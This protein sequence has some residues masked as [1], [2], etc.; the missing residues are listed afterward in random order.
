MGFHLLRMLLAALSLVI[1]ACGS[2]GESTSD[3]KDNGGEGT[4]VPNCG[5][6]ECGD[7]DGCG[8][9]CGSCAGAAVCQAGH[10]AQPAAL[11]LSK[12]VCVGT[13]CGTLQFNTDDGLI[14]CNCGSCDTCKSEC[15]SG[16]CKAKTQV[17]SACHSGGMYW[18]NSCGDWGAFKEACDKGC[19]EGAKAC[20]GCVPSCVGMEC[21]DNGCGGTCGTCSGNDKCVGGLCKA[22]CSPD[23]AGKQCGDNGCGGNCGTCSGGKTCDNG[24]CASTGGCQSAWNDEFSD[25]SAFAS[26][27]TAD[28]HSSFVSTTVFSDSCYS[29][30]TCLYVEGKLNQCWA[31]AYHKGLAVSLPFKVTVAVRHGDEDLEP[32]CHK[33]WNGVDLLSEVSGSGA[34]GVEILGLYNDGIIHGG[35]TSLGSHQ[36]GT[37][38]LVEM[39]VTGA[40]TDKIEVSYSVN[41][42]AKGKA[43]FDLPAGVPV[44]NLLLQ[45]ACLDGTCAFDD[46]AVEQCQ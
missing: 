6:F 29:G 33:R 21:G 9:T 23:C 45:L 18:K 11:C 12:Q 7:H 2:D 4:C 26:A 34:T 30:S 22:S 27:W 13:E 3:V 44:P 8:G 31:G 46:L 35:D 24:S 5:N 41:G 10:C 43:Q 15:E 17:D 1:F 28:W 36:A 19:D 42:S 25:S 16:V 32:G 40:G 14:D 39:A 20:T 38:Y 37:W